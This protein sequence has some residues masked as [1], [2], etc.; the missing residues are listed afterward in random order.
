MHGGTGCVLALLVIH[1]LTLYSATEFQAGGQVR[2]FSRPRTVEG[3][4]GGQVGLDV[5]SVN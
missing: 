2:I 3:K 4:L 5:R 1:A